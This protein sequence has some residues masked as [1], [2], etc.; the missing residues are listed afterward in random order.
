[1]PL[2]RQRQEGLRKKE[3]LLDPDGK[4]AR[5]RPEHVPAHADMIAKVQQMEKAESLLSHDVLPYINLDL[6]ARPLQV[7]KPGFA[8]QAVRYDAPRDPDFLSV[9]FQIATDD[10]RIFA[11]QVCGLIRPAKL[12]RKRLIAKRLNLFEFFLPL[13][14]L[15]SGLELQGEAVPFL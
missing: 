3:K 1:M 9:R 11:Q 8:H 5:L 13:F 15:V 4:L 14:E 2:F 6:L 10:L 12:A 7:G